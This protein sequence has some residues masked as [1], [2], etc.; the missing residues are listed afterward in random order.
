[1]VILFALGFFALLGIAAFLMFKKPDTSVFDRLESYRDG[2]DFGAD[3]GEERAE[4]ENQAA[5]MAKKAAKEINRLAPISA[6]EAKKLEQKL[7]H[8]GY[9]SANATMIF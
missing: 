3:E 6:S 1:M 5:E 7:M 8:A 2:G 4:K 9:R